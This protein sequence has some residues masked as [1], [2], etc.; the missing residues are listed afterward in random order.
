MYRGESHSMD[1]STMIRSVAI[2]S[3]HDL[4]LRKPAWWSLSLASNPVFSLSKM[5]LLT[6]PGLIGALSLCSSDILAY[7]LSLGASWCTY[8]SI[9]MVPVCLAD[10]S[11]VR[12]AFREQNAMR[13][14]E[15]N[16]YR[17]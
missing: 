15:Q 10:S 11:R 9:Q 1:C 2:W 5:T 16:I 13:G 17:V 7:L 12:C 3:V 8:L 6:F 14:G 4:S